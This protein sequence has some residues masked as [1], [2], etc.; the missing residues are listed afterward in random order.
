M[1]LPT[2]AP[3]ER[4]RCRVP[5]GAERDTA[6]RL[7]G[8]V[9]GRKRRPPATRTADS[10]ARSVAP[11]W[12]P[13]TSAMLAMEVSSHVTLVPISVLVTAPSGI[14]PGGPRSS[15]RWNTAM[16]SRPLADNVGSSISSAPPASDR[17]SQW[18]VRTT[19]CRPE[20]PRP[21]EPSMRAPGASWS[22]RARSRSPTVASGSRE[23]ARSSSMSRRCFF[24]MDWSRISA[25]A[26]G[27]HTSSYE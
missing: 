4:K 12:R 5:S 11:V 3:P 7:A 22:P 27:M 19:W 23:W 16:V 1:G 15:L 10:P 9:L 25:S 8:S 13:I 26:P 20:T 18:S 6:D 2:V 17:A 21:P 14:D 24:C